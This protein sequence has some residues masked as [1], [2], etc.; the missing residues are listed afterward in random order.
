M[1]DEPAPVYP[2]GKF[3]ARG[4]P[5][6]IGS[7]LVTTTSRGKGINVVIEDI[8]TTQAFDYIQ[9]RH[10]PQFWFVACAQPIKRLPIQYQ[11]SQPDVVQ[12]SAGVRCSP[13]GG[14]AELINVPMTS[15]R[16]CLVGDASEVY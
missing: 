6:K 4:S 9:A 7:L 13:F 10:R 14:P 1:P 3:G 5:G 15:G 2:T 16:Q 12:L 11:V 8:D